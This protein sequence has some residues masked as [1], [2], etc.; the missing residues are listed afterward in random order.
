MLVFPKK[1][2]FTL[3]ASFVNKNCFLHHFSYSSQF[4]SSFHSNNISMIFCTLAFLPVCQQHYCAFF[5]TNS[6]RFFIFF[7]HQSDFQ[8]KVV[9]DHF[10]WF[11]L[12]KLYYPHIT[13]TA[14]NKY[15][16]HLLHRI[17]STSQFVVQNTKLL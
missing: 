4:H 8:G 9:L 2:S 15:K 13:Q 7:T 10:P 11:S 12:E 1:C 16:Y 3:H 14:N 17:V 6:L 5:L